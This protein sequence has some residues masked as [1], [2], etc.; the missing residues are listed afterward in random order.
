[1]NDWKSVLKADPTRW[2]LEEDNPSVRYFTLRDILERPERDPE[3]ATRSAK[4]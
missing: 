2:L 3:T 1:M 4:M